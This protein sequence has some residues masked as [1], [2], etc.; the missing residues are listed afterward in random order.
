MDL[1]S[2]HI[3]MIEAIAVAAPKILSKYYRED[4]CIVATRIIIEVLKKLHFK[5]VKPFVIE[6]NIFN[7]IYVKKGRTPQSD[8]EAQEWLKDGV[9]QIVLGDRS[10]KTEGKWDGHLVVLINNKYMLDVAVYQACRPHKQIN[11]DPIFTTVPEDFINGE[12]KCQLMFNNCLIVYVSYPQDKTYQSSKDWYDLS[13]SKQVV[14]EVYKEV[15]AIL[16][17]K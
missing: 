9:W 4:C 13:R 16:S 11:L 8:E 7:E 10:K 3:K 1:S 14:G 17:K 12:D 6:A 2:Y 5:D 15:K